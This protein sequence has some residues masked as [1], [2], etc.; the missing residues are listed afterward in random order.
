MG[1]SGRTILVLGFV[2]SRCVLD[3]YGDN[4]DMKKGMN[5][6][7]KLQLRM[8]SSFVCNYP[9]FWKFLTRNYKYN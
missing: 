6:G 2:F 4:R 8:V 9:N 7:L 1:I 3:T 5:N